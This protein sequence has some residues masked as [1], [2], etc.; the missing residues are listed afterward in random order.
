[1]S[2][3]NF[4]E[5]KNLL[6]RQ[7]LS[8]RQIEF[9]VADVLTGDIPLEQYHKFKDS[10]NPYISANATTIVEYITTHSDRK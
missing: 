3:H 8:L 7:I 9:L 5:L 10:D 2:G 6:N 1:M 4:E